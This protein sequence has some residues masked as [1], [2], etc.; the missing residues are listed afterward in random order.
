MSG[1]VLFAKRDQKHLILK[2]NILISAISDM[3]IYD[4]NF[5]VRVVTILWSKVVTYQDRQNYRDSNILRVKL[6][7]INVNFDML[8]LSR[9]SVKNKQFKK[10]N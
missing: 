9:H 4:S 1:F 3:N 8:N 7:Q 5:Q 10:I 6:L 2:C